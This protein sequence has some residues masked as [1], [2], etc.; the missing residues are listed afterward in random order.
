MALLRALKARPPENGNASPLLSFPSILSVT[1]ITRTV[2]RAIILCLVRTDLPQ[3]EILA[4]VVHPPVGVAV[5]DIGTFPPES[6]RHPTVTV[7]CGGIARF[8]GDRVALPLRTFG[9]Q[10]SHCQA[11]QFSCAFM[12]GASGEQIA[13]QERDITM[14]WNASVYGPGVSILLAARSPLLTANSSRRSLLG[15]SMHGFR[16]RSVA[17]ILCT[18]ELNRT[19]RTIEGL[20]LKKG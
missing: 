18:S 8:V 4:G 12:K 14:L 20:I 13:A 11:P 6:V 16:I 2:R 19:M 10:N 3:L 7:R 15:D 5:H 17:S 1:P 9:L